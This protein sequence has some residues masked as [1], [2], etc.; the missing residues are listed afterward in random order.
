MPALLSRS[1]VDAARKR[2]AHAKSR[3]GCGNCKLRR[4]KCD[5]AQPSCRKCKLYGVACD[6]SDRASFLD[7]D[8]RGSFQVQFDSII[9]LESSSSD[10]ETV[11]LCAPDRGTT[12]DQWIPPLQS[13]SIRS[14]LATV[15]DN[16]LQS[17]TSDLSWTENPWRFSKSQL[18]IISRFRE[19]T[20]LT[21]G[22]PRMAPLYRD[23]V[24]EL[25]CKHPFLMH[26]LLS[27][28]LMHDAHL[29]DPLTGATTTY[30]SQTALEHWNRASKL[31][32]DVLSRPIPPSYRD[33]IWATG[34]FLGAAS[35]WSIGSTS[36]YNVW[37]LKSPEPDDL[38]WLKIGEGKKHLW[39]LA[40]PLRSDSIFC[41]LAKEN[42][43]LSVPE[44]AAIKTTSNSGSHTLS[45][46]LKLFGMTGLADD[47]QDAYYHPILVLSRCPNVKL[48]QENALKFLYVMAVITPEFLELLE[49]K[50]KK[51]IFIM[52]WWY[53]L[54]TT[55]DLWWMTRRARIEGQAIRI[56]LRR[57][58]DGGKFADL[59]DDM[60][61]DA[62]R[63]EAERTWFFEA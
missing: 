35:F 25:A 9:V 10:D 4:V 27:V 7:L 43:C 60:E 54:L 14:S 6:Y 61:R 31:F 13:M 26:M 12:L 50:D 55:G 51:A 62:G 15:I 39:R 47:A 49:T 41:D 56:W 32:N 20:A 18:D 45:R 17:K 16:S 11:D 29:V 33:A 5:E 44:W 37:P 2:R 34:V 48:T 46:V 63:E 38:S 23:L 36:P 22:N 24:C 30:S 59:L 8:A 52:G 58:N 1:G 28:T 42:S 57:Q 53:I 40:Q 3:K 21:I 19:R